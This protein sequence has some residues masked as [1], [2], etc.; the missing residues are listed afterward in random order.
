MLALHA[1]SREGSKTHRA[2]WRAICA[3]AAWRCCCGCAV[4]GEAGMGVAAMNLPSARCSS[5]TASRKKRNAGRA[6]LTTST[7]TP[8]AGTTATAAMGQTTTAAAAMAAAD[9]V[10]CSATHDARPGT[11]PPLQSSGG[12]HRRCLDCQQHESMRALKRHTTLRCPHLIGRQ[13][14]LKASLQQ[15]PMRLG[16]SGGGWWGSHVA[17]QRACVC[18]ET[19]VCGVCASDGRSPQPQSRHRRTAHLLPSPRQ[20]GVSAAPTSC[21]PPL[22][23]VG[24]GDALEPPR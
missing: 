6:V 9:T 20:R 16:H 5:T 11:C 19:R 17:Q 8:A 4:D 12:S 21:Q 15:Q 7:D 10:A 2:R 13:Q 18:D 1:D 23:T 14:L 3:S 22:Q 24:G